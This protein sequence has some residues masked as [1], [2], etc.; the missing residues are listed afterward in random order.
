MVLE[1]NPVQAFRNFLFVVLVGGQII[2]TLS[3]DFVSQFQPDGSRR[4]NPSLSDGTLRPLDV[5]IIVGGGQLAF[6]I[7]CWIV[8]SIRYV[9]LCML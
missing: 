2:G 5:H 6:H 4:C 9:S 3:G 8:K 7:D 1:S